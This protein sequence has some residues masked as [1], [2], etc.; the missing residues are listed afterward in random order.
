MGNLDNFTAFGED[1]ITSLPLSKHRKFSRKPKKE[2]IFPIMFCTLQKPNRHVDAI[3][4]AAFLFLLPKSPIFPALNTGW[5]ILDETSLISLILLTAVDFLVLD[6][7]IEYVSDVQVS[8]IKISHIWLESQK[9][10][11][12]TICSHQTKKNSKNCLNS[13]IL[14]VELVLSRICHPVSEIGSS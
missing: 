2:R 13:L 6:I 9:I 12:A 11:C 1:M 8:K 7:H 3:F 14:Q 10:F 5:Q 4:N